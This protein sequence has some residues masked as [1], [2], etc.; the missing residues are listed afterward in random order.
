MILP[1]PPFKS[2][3]VLT[4]THTSQSKCIDFFKMPK[5]FQKY[6]PECFHV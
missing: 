2:A 3:I 4:D 5:H 6:K 1:A